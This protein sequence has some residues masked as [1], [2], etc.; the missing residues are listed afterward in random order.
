MLV[1][2]Q[3]GSSHSTS[4]QLA[5]WIFSRIVSRINEN[6][7]CRASELNLDDCLLVPCPDLMS[8]IFRKHA[9]RKSA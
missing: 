4:S 9:G 1:A 5:G 6:N 8:V 2:R 3:L 7:I